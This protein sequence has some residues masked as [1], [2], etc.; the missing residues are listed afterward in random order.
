MQNQH[1][2]LAIVGI[3]CRFPGGVT[4]IDSY[5]D[6]LVNGRSGITEVPPERWD[7][8]KYYHHNQEVRGRMVTKWGGFIDSFDQFDARFFGITPREAQRMDPQQRWL[9]ETSWEALEDAGLPPSSLRGS[10]TGVFVGISSHDHIDIY[11]GDLALIDIHTGSGSALSIA[12]NRISYTFDFTGPSLAVDTAC[13]SA[14]TATSLACH[15]LWSGQ[16]QMALVGGVNVLLNPNVSIGFSKASMLSPDGRCFAFDHRANGYVR[17]EG[18]GVVVIKPLQQAKA[19]GDRVYAVIRGAVTNQDGHTSSLTVPSLAAQVAMLREAYQVTG[20]DPSRVSYVEAHGTGTPVGDPI[21][22]TALGQVFGAG[23]PE[24][25]ACLIGSVKSNIGHLEA[26]SGMAGLIKAAMV[27]HHQL[28]PSQL[29]FEQVNPNIP[30]TDLGLQ[31]VTRNRPLPRLD[32]RPVI[33]G[34]NSFGFGGANAHIVLEQAPPHQWL[35][36]EQPVAERP[37]LLPLSAPDEMALQKQAKTY[38]AFL[39]TTDTTPAEIATAAGLRREQFAQRLVVIGADSTSLRARLGD[40][41]NSD[42]DVPGL[43]LGQPVAQPQPPVFV[44]TGQGA[45]WWGMGHQ[46]LDRE[47]LFRQSV[48]RSD[49]QFQQLSGWSLLAELTKNKVDSRIDRTDI[50]QPVIFA[51][52]VALTDLWRS[53]G[54]R[55]GGVIGHSVGEVAAACVAGIFSLADAIKIIYHRS[56]LQTRTGGKGG[57]VAVGLSLAEA[58]LA[59]NNRDHQVQVAAINSP[60]LVTL[61]GEAAAIKALTDQM[62]QEGKFVRRL[63]INYAFH[64]Y[65][66]DEIQ[67]ELLAAL[68]DIEPQPALIPFM[69]T[70]TAGM[71]TG[72]TLDADYWW[73]N[74]RQPVRF[75]PAVAE[76]VQSGYTTYLE[77]GPHPA[78]QH[79]IHDCLAEQGQTGTVCHSLRREH[80]ESFELL[81]NLAR[82]HAYGLPV[83]WEAVNQ[84]P[85][86]FTRLPG[87]PWQRQKQW[88]TSN[89]Q[90]QN[91]L[92]PLAHPLLGMRLPAPHP[93]WEHQFDPRVLEYLNDHQIWGGIVFPA[94]GF[95]EMGL[96]AARL[97][98]A[99]DDY[100][101]ESLQIKKALF[102]ST[103]QLPTVRLIFDEA[104]KNFSIFSTVDDKASWQIHA[105]GQLRILSSGELTAVDIRAIQDRLPFLA[106]KEQYYQAYHSMG[107]EFGP[108]FQQIE[109]VWCSSGQALVKVV[110]SEPVREQAGEYHFH[111]ALL[112]ACLQSVS[113]AANV[114]G[115]YKYDTVPYLPAV[116]GRITLFVEPIPTTF[117]VWTTVVANELHAITADF[118]VI[119]TDGNPVAE[120]LGDDLTG[121]SNN[122]IQIGWLLRSCIRFN[123]RLTQLRRRLCRSRLSHLRPRPRTYCL[124]TQAE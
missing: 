79:S 44:F 37:Y 97:M 7:W 20:I 95:G 29:N 93:T 80:D 73:R 111:P 91:N 77:V 107:Y 23:R 12:A 78:L 11:Q 100:V 116:F 47:P 27:L 85:G 4:D 67:S 55:P 8:R 31:V 118:R 72:P 61:S 69:S 42:S 54:I 5:W 101:V 121:C 65:Q 56:R 68:A 90:R 64:S 82:L 53:W 57:M 81:T 104:E 25:V 94:A 74:I 24:E 50:A 48:E 9:L 26:A 30:L 58:N 39:T 34:V 38:E 105:R 2:P 51:L 96:A 40:Y 13:S 88:L 33:V 1:Q 49:A 110:A 114:I 124:Q 92:E 35:T 60:N 106:E 62:V 19:D 10:R 86:G 70:V 41:L 75:A 102:I 6:L 84:T 112:D 18:V 43:I 123:G 120:I 99:E 46:L 28:I 15:S 113:A 16:C 3:G 59:V 52:Q 66:M 21:E 63:P 14:L 89:M 32:D 108:A 117:W 87:Y 45:Q 98:F 122:R 17:G 22:A 119:D 109:N 76:L 115:D 83:A 71:I 103:T 36:T